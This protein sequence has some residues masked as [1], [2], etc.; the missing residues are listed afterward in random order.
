MTANEWRP[1]ILHCELHRWRRWS[2]HL[3]PWF[4]STQLS[5]VLRIHLRVRCCLVLF[6]LISCHPHVIHKLS[7]LHR[8]APRTSKLCASHHAT[9]VKGD[10]L[11]KAPRLSTRI[12]IL[13]INE[14]D[15]DCFFLDDLGHC[16]I[17]S[18]RWH[19]NA[20]Y[21]DHSISFAL[22][23]FITW[24]LWL[25]SI[26]DYI[27]WLSCPTT[28]HLLVLQ[29]LWYI[30][31]NDTSCKSFNNSSLS[32]SWLANDDLKQQGGS[33]NRLKSGEVETSG[34]TLPNLQNAPQAYRQ[35]TGL[36]F[37]LLARIW[38]TSS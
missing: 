19:F 12:A 5:I 21:T 3:S 10:H 16:S 34:L 32:N 11:K 29:G 2:C 28:R 20:L 36:F 24:D 9:N 4:L 38:I 30:S 22:S 33:N 15:T 7:R 8:S 13:K 14:S 18:L 31:I 6:G 1:I 35:E 25:W 27:D 26:I 17:L 23:W 37:D